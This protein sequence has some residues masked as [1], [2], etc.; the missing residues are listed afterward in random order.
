[1]RNQRNSESNR[2]CS[3]PATCVVSPLTEGMSSKLTID[4][5]PGVDI[6]EQRAWPN[7][8]DPANQVV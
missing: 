5:Q 7:N 6:H 1:M 3:D 8:L 2:S 4:V